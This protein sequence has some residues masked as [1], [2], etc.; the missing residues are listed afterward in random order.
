[1]TSP[2]PDDTAGRPSPD[3][4][5]PPTH[6]YY[7]SPQPP[8]GQDPYQQPQ[9]QAHGQPPYPQAPYGYGV[10]PVPQHPSATTAMVLGVV[11]LAGLMFC[12]GITLVLSPFAWHIGARAVRE[13]DQDPRRYGGRD[14]ANAGK[15]T[16]IIGTVLLVIAIIL[17]IGLIVGLVM[18]DT[19]TTYEYDTGTGSTAG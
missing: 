5:L 10:P 7:G 15:I 17:V 4:Q 1:M 8:Y 2:D 16:G 18:L 12:G 19:P 3:P 6:Q 14:Q 13:I 11:G 9:Q